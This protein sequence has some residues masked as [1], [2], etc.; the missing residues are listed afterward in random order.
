MMKLGHTILRFERVASTN[1]VAKDLA[2]SG[3]PEGLCIIGREQTAGRGRQ[4]RSWS[5]PAAEGLYLS[6]I[7]RPDIA[8]A[9]AAIIT[10]AAAV[11]VA[12]TLQLDYQVPA[13]IK[14]PNDVLTSGR[15]ISG[16]LIESAIESD[17][18]QYAVLGVGV[19]IAQ[20]SFAA[21]I[22]GTATSLL[23]ETG[24]AISPED[25]AKPLLERLE[26]WYKL[27]IVRA[28]QVIARWEELSSYA[29]GRK[30]RVESSARSVVGFTKGLT[31]H[32]ALRVEL[33][34]GE[35]REIVSGEVSLLA[36]SS[37]N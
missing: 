29:R 34:N 17:K 33:A 10:L 4:G 18:L 7:L 11:A 35:I 9:N 2:T 24:E 26:S 31:P 15:K 1:D 22:A 5:S 6:V 14:W 37:S 19:N 20:Q 13:D 36:A 12:E 28:D 16:I 21:E 27:A 23:L 8:A 3:A 30:V 32:G 25:F